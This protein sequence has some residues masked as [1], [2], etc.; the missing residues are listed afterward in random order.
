MRAAILI[1]SIDD[2]GANRVLLQD[3]E[4]LAEL[5]VQVSVVAPVDAVLSDE[6]VK[7]IAAMG[8]DLEFFPLHVFRRVNLRRSLGL[9][10]NLPSA[11]K[12]ADLVI[13]YT[14]AVAGYL[15]LLRLH[16]IPS[17]LSA[18][19]IL[20]GLEGR[21]LGVLAG[22]ANQVVV[23]SMATARCLRGMGL[24]DE[25]MTLMYPSLPFIDAPRST[26]DTSML[27]LL[28]AARVNGAKGQADAVRAVREVRSEGIPIELTLA[29]G[30]FP[31]QE[32]WVTRLRGEIGD[33]PGVH[34]VGDRPD[35]DDL[36]VGSNL[37]LISSRRPESFGFVALEA[38]C[39]GRRSIAPAEGG[40]LEAMWLVDG[41]TYE[42]RHHQSLA[43]QLSRLWEHPAL[44]SEPGRGAPVA[45]RCSPTRRLE[46]WGELL[47]LPVLRR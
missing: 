21:L 10:V 12:E 44:L 20:D 46:A 19:E 45:D 42:P 3:L 5:G 11:A 37:L 33:D 30:P 18:H 29:G 47:E 32:E 34:Y 25:R 16:R 31:G 13:A 43:R 35:I 36:L 9:P 6:Q 2:Y 7:R 15:P 41:L 22:S 14:L 40:A 38:W 39:L 17:V 28:V 8:V 4:A 27:R 1:G 26:V 23:N 24:H